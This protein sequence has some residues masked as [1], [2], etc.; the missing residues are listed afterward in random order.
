MSDPC[1]FHSTLFGASAHIDS[2]FNAPESRRT[3]YHGMQAVGLL[4]QML[5]DQDARGKYETA[6]SV[7]TLALFNVCT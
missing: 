7:L 5:H 1:L 6:A 2:L 4:R 3:T